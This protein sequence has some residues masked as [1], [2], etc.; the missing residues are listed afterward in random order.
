M[1]QY[2]EGGTWG[3]PHYEKIMA[4]QAGALRAYAAATRRTRDPRWAREAR[5]V[6]GWL[7][8]FLR[9]P[10]GA[11]GTSQDADLRRPDG[12]SVDGAAYFGRDDAGRRAL[13][14][15]RIDRAVY[16][17]ENGWAVEGLAALATATGD[18]AL[19]DEAETAARAV[20][21]THDDGAGGLRHAADDRGPLHLGDQAACGRAAVVLWGATGDRA[22]LARAERL[23]ETLRARFLDP[24][25]G[26]FAATSG[27]AGPFGEALRPFDGNVAA[28]RFLLALAAAKD[29]ARWRREALRAM[30]VA[31][32]PGVPERH[33]WRSA[34]LLLAVEE[35]MRPVVR[36]TVV[37]EPDDPRTCLLYTSPSPRD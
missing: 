8:G 22:W 36:A 21:A 11:F 5:A 10:S 20:F 33:G 23:A 12:S 35:A 30:A 18:A 3:T 9:A 13:G 1:Y 27:A 24:A 17:Q 14:M 29:D 28:A 34:A 4:V 16:A 2:S 7:R 15:P 25:R 6:V 31:A 32:A 26:G 19:L 37:G